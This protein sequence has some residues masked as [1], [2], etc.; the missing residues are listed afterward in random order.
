MKLNKTLS[1]LKRSAVSAA[2]ISGIAATAVQVQADTFT[3]SIDTI[4]PVTITEIQPLFF[5]TQLNLAAFGTCAFPTLVANT[6]DWVGG[7]GNFALLPALAI[8]KAVTGAGCADTASTTSNLGHYLISGG[9]STPV[10]ITL[11]TGGATGGEF[12]FAPQGVADNLISANTGG[13]ALVA[14]AQQTITSDT[15]GNIGLLVGGQIDVG[16]T[17][18][19]SGTTLPASFDINVVY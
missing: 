10:K 18:L 12:T 9:N 7:D 19:T 17:A 6:D 5:G 11:V 8:P 2:L 13:I 3:F 1:V 4:A 16:I 15:S 14:D